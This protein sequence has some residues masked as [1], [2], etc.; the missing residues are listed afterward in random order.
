MLTLAKTLS[1]TD[2][3]HAM[4]ETH[5]R[6]ISTLHNTLATAIRLSNRRNA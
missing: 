4:E 5:R 3:A 2:W 6:A 1:A